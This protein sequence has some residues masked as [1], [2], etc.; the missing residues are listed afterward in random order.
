MARALPN[1][2]ARTVRADGEGLIFR[3]QHGLEIR[4]D[5]PLAASRERVLA[6]GTPQATLMNY[7][8]CQPA[9]LADRL[10][11]E[12]F[13]GSGAI[14]LT[15]LRAGARRVELLDVNPRAVRFARENAERNGFGS[16]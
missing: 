1:H 9:R 10:V 6:L 4:T 5:A 11:F 16:E 13:A 8:L 15:A 7:M 2:I 3:F 14:G 12:P